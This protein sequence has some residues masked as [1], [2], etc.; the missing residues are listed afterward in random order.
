MEPV[1]DARELVP[2]DGSVPV[3]I[4]DVEQSPQNDVKALGVFIV[5]FMPILIR[6][7]VKRAVPC[8]ISRARP[9]QPAPKAAAPKAA[10]PKAAAARLHFDAKVGIQDLLDSYLVPFQACVEGGGVSC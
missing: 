8:P 1:H 7:M 5:I 9:D 2:I 6:G 3:S 4:K 10:A